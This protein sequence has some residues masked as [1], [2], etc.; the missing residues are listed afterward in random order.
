MVAY[1]SIGQLDGCDDD[2]LDDIEHAES[3][4]NKK[5]VKTITIVNTNARS[6]CPKIE[7]LIDRLSRRNGRCHWHRH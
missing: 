2:V 6:L 5:E 4:E 1:E 3:Q 7:S